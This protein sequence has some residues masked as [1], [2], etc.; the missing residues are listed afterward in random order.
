MKLKLLACVSTLIYANQSY[1]DT[2]WCT[3]KI[4]NTYVAANSG[5]YIKPG[6]G[7]W[8]YLCNL[9]GSYNSIETTTCNA[10]LSMAQVSIAAD[11]DLIIKLDNVTGTC[12]TQGDNGSFPKPTYVQLKK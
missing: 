3:G 2:L 12:E 4:T 11:K 6:W 7:D 10:W 9:N 8:K 1:S 5:L